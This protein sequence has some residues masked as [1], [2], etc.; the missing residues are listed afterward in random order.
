[1]LAL[2]VGLVVAGGGSILAYLFKGTVGA[3]LFK[4]PPVAQQTADIQQKM[5]EEIINKP[6]MSQTEKNLQNGTF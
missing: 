1:M 4:K 2:I 3:W 6:T 5:D